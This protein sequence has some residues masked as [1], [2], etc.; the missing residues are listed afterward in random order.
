[1]APLQC[2]HSLLEPPPQ[3]RI[4]KGMLQADGFE[5]LGQKDAAIAVLQALVSQTPNV[6]VQQR[7]DR[8]QGKAPA[9]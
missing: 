6:R 4:R 5:A 8:L 2:I 3:L 7:I 9:P 1:M